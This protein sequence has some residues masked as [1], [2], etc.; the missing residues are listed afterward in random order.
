MSELMR[1]FE[2]DTLSAAWHAKRV[3]LTQVAANLLLLAVFYGWLLLPDRR[4]W[5]VGATF[6][7]G[8]AWLTI[9]LWLHAATFQYFAAAHSSPETWK[10]SW[11]RSARN[12]PAFAICVAI[13]FFFIWL[14]GLA[15]DRQGQL[16]GWFHHLAPGFIRSH[17][18]VRTMTLLTHIKAVIIFLVLLPLYLFPFLRE[19]AV[20]GFGAFAKGW[21]SAGRSFWHLR[22]WGTWIVLMLLGH[23]PFHLAFAKPHAGTLTAQTVSMVLRLGVGYLLL[24]SVY[25]LTVS[26]VGRLRRNE[27]PPAT[28]PVPVESAPKV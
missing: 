28:K 12:L 2:R 4:G 13:L 17:M 6:L 22:W 15:F 21:A 18:S 3:W 10:M 19:G 24:V 23:L 1:G 8:L 26:A 25:V 20:R 11:R 5:Q 16:G 7:I 27:S 9:S 14:M